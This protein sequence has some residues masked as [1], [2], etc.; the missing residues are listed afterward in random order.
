M[1]PARRRLK[2]EP[3]S[4]TYN[5]GRQEDGY[6]IERGG[7]FLFLNAQDAYEVCCQLADLIDAANATE[8]Q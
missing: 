3:Y 2:V 4:W 6:R 1:N 5:S 7:A 8:N